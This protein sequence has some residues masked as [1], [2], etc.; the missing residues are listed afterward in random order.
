MGSSQPAN[1]NNVGFFF[2]LH[3]F[4][5]SQVVNS[6]LGGIYECL[7]RSYSNFW[8]GG[9]GGVSLDWDHHQN[10]TSE[11]ISYCSLRRVCGL[12]GGLKPGSCQL[13]LRSKEMRMSHCGVFHGHGARGGNIRRWHAE[14]LTHGY[15]VHILRL[16]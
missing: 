13:L 11:L 3:T 1:T 5:L 15:I 12:S 8:G 14:L 7:S 10:H 9:P 2:F 4:N 6:P 16:K